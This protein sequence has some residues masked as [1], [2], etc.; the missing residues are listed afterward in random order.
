MRFES[1][2]SLSKYQ[3]EQGIHGLCLLYGAEEYLV[4]A[5]KNRIIKPF[6]TAGAFGLH[7]LDGRSLDCDALYDAVESLPFGTP[8]SSEAGEKCVVADDLDMSKLQPNDQDKLLDAAANLPPGCVL[9][10]TGKG[11]FDPKS[12][13][14]KKLIKLAGERGIAAELGSR[15]QSGLVQ[16]LRNAAK[17]SGCELS[18]PLA[19]YI[20][21][22]CGNDMNTLSNEL[23]KICARAGYVQITREH[24]DD[25]ATPR[26]EARVF[27][28]SRAILNSRP[29]QVMDILADLF[30][31]REQ[32][33]S[34]LS[35]LSMSFVDL[36][37][38]RNARDCGMTQNVFAQKFGYKSEYRVRSAYN[39][40]HSAVA[41]AHA[42]EALYRCDIKIKSTGID[43][44]VLI[45]QTVVKLLELMSRE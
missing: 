27:D 11:A 14:A 28:L 32:P 15:G 39:G 26:V 20:L 37:R 31:L 6:R 45:E 12:A 18:A 41:L 4:D 10:I 22:L 38:A 19:R 2:E 9:V 21:E 29:S 3:R 44:R 5:W 17:R 30:A 42:L 13:A 25:T 33:I 7:M 36:Y 8:G 40:R 34:I 23:Q 24:I 16:F 35:V 1:E 43:G